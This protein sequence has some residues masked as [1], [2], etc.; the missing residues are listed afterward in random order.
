MED[1]QEYIL[2]PTP[3]CGPNGPKFKGKGTPYQKHVIG[4][5]DTELLKIST[6]LKEL[7]TPTANNKDWIKKQI[8]LSVNR[9]TELGITHGGLMEKT[10]QT[11]KGRLFRVMD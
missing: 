8:E 1:K 2:C 6:G 4:C 10:T 11:T 9:I 7:P 5:L 3:T